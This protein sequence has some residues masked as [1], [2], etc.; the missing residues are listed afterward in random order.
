MCGEY[1]H[2]ATLCPCR[3]YLDP[4][5]LRDLESGD[6]SRKYWSQD[7][8]ATWSNY[9]ASGAVERKGQLSTFLHIVIISA[10]C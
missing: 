2:T 1:S 10:D 7:L 4:I 8:P 3:N 5:E 9:D 6:L